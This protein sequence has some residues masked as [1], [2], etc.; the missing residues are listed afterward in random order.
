M[1]NVNAPGVDSEVTE[2]MELF[3]A[4]VADDLDMLVVLHAEEVTRERIE[5]LKSVGFPGNLGLHMNNEQ[6]RDA[7]Q[8]LAEALKELPDPP[9]D[10][11]LDQLAS[12]YAAVYI[13]NTYRAAPAESAWLDEDGLAFQQPMFQVRDWYRRYGLTVQNWRKR[14]DDHLVMQ[15]QFISYLCRRSA[16]T[17]DLREIA[18]FLDEHLL[19]WQMDFA[20]RVAARC[21]TA[22]YA[23]LCLLT[24]AYCDRLRDL[25]VMVTGETRPDPEGTEE[26]SNTGQHIEDVMIQ[27]VPG[28]TPSW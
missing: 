17:E 22:F 5:Q 10:A 24:A 6:G 2:P 21:E 19:R 12:D 1:I 11:V 23:G 13:N 7:T 8:L 3:S 9:D 15:L 18:R 26:R 4:A 20:R 25:I 14:S 28:V 27:Y 16:S